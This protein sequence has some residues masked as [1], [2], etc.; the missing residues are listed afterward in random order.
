L[1]KEGIKIKQK[2]HTSEHIHSMFV[3]NTV[4]VNLQWHTYLQRH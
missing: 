3:N 1:I 2:Q 4:L